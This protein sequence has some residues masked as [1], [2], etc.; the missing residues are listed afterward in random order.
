MGFFCRLF[1]P[2]SVRRA[3]H[4]GRGVRRAVT[5]KAVKRLQRAT[6]PID[7]AFYSWQRFA[8]H[9]VAPAGRRVQ[10]RQLPGEAPNAGSCR[11][12]PK[13]LSRDRTRRTARP[14][15][16]APLRGARPLVVGDLQA[17]APQP[18]RRRAVHP[19][20]DDPPALAAGHYARGPP[21]DCLR[22]AD[23]ASP[24]VQPAAK[25]TRCTRDDG[26]PAERSRGR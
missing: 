4:P 2:R 22:V 10:T 17:H 11:T 26:L 13:P 6:H 24:P 25:T 18:A 3:V 12:L 1:V 23:A 20:I 19:L 21:L 9:Q 15:T 16:L 7:N 5:P 8:E 14:G